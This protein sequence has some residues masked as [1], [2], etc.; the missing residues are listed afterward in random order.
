MTDT[1]NIT[2][3]KL[4]AW[5]G[6]VRKTATD[7]GIEELAASIAAHGLLQSLVVRK[8]G[9]NKY[10]VVA[11]GRRLQALQRLAA[12]G[13]IGKDAP[14][15]CQILAAETDA[16]EI[17]L[18]ENTV[19]EQMH[20][21]DEFEAFRDLADKGIPPADIA[22]RFGVTETVVLKRL[23]LAR[24][25]PV[26]L[27]AY[28]K[29]DLTMEQVMA[30]AV[31][32]DHEAQERLL[33]NLPPWNADP[34]TI[35]GSLTEQEISATDRRVKLATLKAYEKAGGKTRRDLF[36]DDDHGIFILDPALLDS[37]VMKKLEKTAEA[38]RKEG[39]KWV[40][41]RP[42]YDYAELSKCE[43]RY[44]EDVPLLPDQ[45]QEYDALRDEYNGMIDTSDDTDPQVSSRLDEI[46]ARMNQLDDRATMWPPETLA[47][48]GAVV[49]IGHQ[50]EADI[51]RGFVLPED[52]PKKQ[53]KSATA[54][55]TDAEGNV[56][57]VETEPASSHSA[58]LIESLTAH[59]SAAISVAL[60]DR[61]DI[62]LAAVVHAMARRMLFVADS[63]DSCLKL[64]ASAQSFRRVEGSQAFASLEAARQ[65][66]S[67]RLPADCE[68][69]F[70]QWCLAQDQ[71]VLLDLLAFCTA[72]T[73]DAVR[74]KADSPDSDR[75]AH[76]DA[77]AASLKLDMAQ[78]FTPTAEN[79][80]SR[81]SKAAILQ[82]LQEAKGT[83]LSPATAKLSKTELA[84]QAGRTV[85]GTGWL[86]A[87]LRKAT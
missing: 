66:W 79:Y 44:E 6:N 42:S 2:L 26:I 29:G 8:H 34:D 80:F 57:T 52:K 74:L 5:E 77:L 46:E 47:I 67:E 82:A 27:V 62:A 84:A 24:G 16:T 35:R 86:P 40:E 78:W 25:S 11:G 9:K 43:R 83:P 12:S 76:A 53:A 55:T 71:S 54:T 72:S 69:A 65:S 60:L 32:D 1:V 81:I 31:S 70:W 58:A 7:S 63:R 14:V 28:R 4:V 10:A 36:A 75:I 38:I 56:T 20:P 23:K 17:S 68:D 3:D 15:P 33:E 18:A 73:I 85:A 41:I 64:F 61:P 59:R 22:A 13:A 49:S 39:W 30:F 50:G 45:Q 87:P 19:R 48:A 37:L 21:A 51:H